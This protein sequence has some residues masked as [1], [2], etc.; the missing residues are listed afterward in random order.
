[1]EELTKYR[2]ATDQIIA[3]FRYI[4][5]AIFANVD[6]SDREKLID[7]LTPQLTEVVRQHRA[8]VYEE[9]KIMLRAAAKRQGVDNPYEPS[10]S[11]YSED[12]VRTVLRKNLRGTP[13]ESAQAVV[14]A[15]AQHVEAAGR[16]TII[17]SVEDGVVA[18][19]PEDEAHLEHTRL[20]PEEFDEQQSN[21]LQLVFDADSDETEEGERNTALGTQP[22][23]WARV[24]SGAENCGFCV[25]LASRGPVYSSAEN[26]GRGEA[27]DRDY[28]AGV[29]TYHANCDCLAV[30]IY[31]Y[32]KWPGRDQWLAAERVYKHVISQKWSESYNAKH[33]R[34]K[35]KEKGKDRKGIR[36]GYGPSKIT[37]PGQSKKGKTNNV[38]NAMDRYIRSH[39]ISDLH[40]VENIRA[41]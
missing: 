10:M 20:T 29:N 25:I 6:Y 7:Q 21:V 24:L 8:R 4:L 14:N 12:S 34:E 41:A 2:N 28:A 32:A 13:Q 38:I 30:P 1:M 31:D 26:A 27:S 22:T 39:D 5:Q 16:Q 19:D 11:G 9:S 36:A 23:A 37:A 17:R 15:L 33:L 18:A 40:G 3:G 35:W